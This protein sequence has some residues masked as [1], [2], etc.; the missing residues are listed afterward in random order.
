MSGEI[1]LGRLRLDGAYLSARLSTMMIRFSDPPPLFFVQSLN[2]KAL[3]GIHVSSAYP[4]ARKSLFYFDIFVLLEFF[5]FS[6]CAGA[7][8][9]SVYRIGLLSARRLLCA[10][11]VSRTRPAHDDGRRHVGQFSTMERRI[12]FVTSLHKNLFAPPSFSPHVRVNVFV[13]H[14]VM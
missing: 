14:I 6:R 1:I 8:A 13:T 11:A 7:H 4:C 9:H 3:K 10:C 5:R 2:S 12:R